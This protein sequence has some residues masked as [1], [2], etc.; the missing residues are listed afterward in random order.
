MSLQSNEQIIEKVKALQP[1]DIHD[2][3]TPKPLDNMHKETWLQLGENVNVFIWRRLIRNHD[4]QVVEGYGYEVV[5]KLQP[6]TI[7][8]SA[9]SVDLEITKSKVVAILEKMSE[10]LDHFKSIN[11]KSKIEDIHDLVDRLT[12]ETYFRNYP[13]RDVLSHERFQRVRAVINNLQ[14]LLCN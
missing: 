2:P 7:S 13:E 1:E 9:C 8:Q 10:G 12:V 14:E 4:D 5:N 11:M 3:L 6:E